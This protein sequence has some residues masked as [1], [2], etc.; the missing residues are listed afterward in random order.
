VKARGKKVMT[1]TKLPA[2]NMLSMI[3]KLT[4]H[5]K[6]LKNNHPDM[7]MP[8]LKLWARNGQHE[9]FE[10]PP[11]IPLFKPII[12]FGASFYCYM[13]CWYY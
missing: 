3:R 1:T 5:T 7:D 8:R 2:A 9:S 4:K 6:K 13:L 11:N 12:I 10:D